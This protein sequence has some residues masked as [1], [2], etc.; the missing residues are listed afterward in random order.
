MCLL[1]HVVTLPIPTAGPKTNKQHRLNKQC[2]CD[3]SEVNVDQWSAKHRDYPE[4][5]HLQNTQIQ[6]KD[7][8]IFCVRL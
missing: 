4:I 8:H 6:L 3:T 1:S 5:T 7:F 2:S